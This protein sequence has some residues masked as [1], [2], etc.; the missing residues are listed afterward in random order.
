[1]TAPAISIASSFARQLRVPVAPPEVTETG[2][3]VLD[4][5]RAAPHDQSCATGARWE[6]EMDTRQWER[7][8]AATGIVF[9]ILQAAT[10]PLMGDSPDFDAGAGEIRE[11]L[12]D[13]GGTILLA[14]TLN[15]L[16]AFFFIWFLGSLRSVLRVAEGGAG[17]LSATAF[18]AGLVTIALA[19][20]AS[21]PITAFAWE[22]TAAVAEDGLLRVAWNLN[23]LAFTPLG[24]TGAAFILAVT[25]LI[26]RTRLFPAWVGWFGLLSGVVQLVGV[27]GMVADDYDSPLGLFSFGG[28]VT[29]M[30][31]ILIVSIYMVIELGGNRTAAAK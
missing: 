30:L 27:F 6:A 8:A 20:G 2:P 4:A 17:R 11:Y 23:F 14:T 16:S 21:V 9:V 18:G 7:L 12:V 22:D 19:V 29:T 25:V 28:Y 15:A 1:M 31:F 5:G 3:G 24:A 26:F 10:G 13:D